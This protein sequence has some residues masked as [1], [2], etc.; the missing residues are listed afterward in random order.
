MLMRILLVV[1][2]LGGEPIDGEHLELRV[3]VVLC[4]WH[5]QRAISVI[6]ELGLA[7]KSVEGER[8]ERR[9][10]DPVL[11]LGVDHDVPPGLPGEPG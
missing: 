8:L 3:S 10:P 5:L 11:E 1:A 6:P 7:R 2:L 4:C 9:D